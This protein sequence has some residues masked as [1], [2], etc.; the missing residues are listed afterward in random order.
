MNEKQKE[1]KKIIRM[2]NI[3]VEQRL[4]E[5]VYVIVEKDFQ[6]E[7]IKMM[8][9]VNVKEEEYIMEDLYVIMEKSLK[10]GIWEN[11][12][13][14][15]KCP[16]ETVKKGNKCVRRCIGRKCGGVGHTVVQKSLNQ[17]LN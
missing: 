8:I 3:K 5:D 2:V 14:G 15:K 13:N 16:L 12:D 11:I 6:M 7:N 4:M 17:F 10:N 1:M 9:L